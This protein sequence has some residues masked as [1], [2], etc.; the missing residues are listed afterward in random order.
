MAKD[1]T[2]QQWLDIL[3]DQS[4]SDYELLIIPALVE[5]LILG[6]TLHP[7]TRTAVIYNWTERREL[8]E[9]VNEVS[10]LIADMVYLAYTVKG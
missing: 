1:Y 10:Y 8:E 4:L 9:K 6:L 3:S 5:T 2:F 7:G